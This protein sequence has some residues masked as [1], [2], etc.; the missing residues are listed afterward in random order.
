MPLGQ[1]SQLCTWSPGLIS[2]LVASPSLEICYMT[3]S[4]IITGKSEYRK[5][6]PELTKIIV[7]P[8]DQVTSVPYRT[9]GLFSITPYG[10]VAPI[11]VLQ[12]FKGP[13]LEACRCR[14]LSTNAATRP[15][16]SV[17]RGPHLRYPTMTLWLTHYP[18]NL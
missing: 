12:P 5:Y 2:I 16:L 8:G 1:D 18:A 4:L 11:Q 14:Q 6:E 9:S 7:N 17:L 3:G 10:P 13:V 15:R